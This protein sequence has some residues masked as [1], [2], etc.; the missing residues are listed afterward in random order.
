MSREREEGAIMVG[1]NQ[2]NSTRGLRK[3]RDRERKRAYV[4]VLANLADIHP[5][6]FVKWGALN[7]TP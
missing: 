7:A 1:Q 6:T 2:S 5:W 3:K 4:F